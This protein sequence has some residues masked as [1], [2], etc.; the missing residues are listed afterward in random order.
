MHG[1]PSSRKPFDTASAESCDAAVA[2]TAWTPTVIVVASGVHAGNGGDAM[3]VSGAELAD[4]GAS[5]GDADVASDG[6]DDVDDA[7]DAG[8]GAHGCGALTHVA[9]SKDAGSAGVVGSAAC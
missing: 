3:R 1:R 4:G 7:G 6:A 5:D 2:S 8:A 9:G